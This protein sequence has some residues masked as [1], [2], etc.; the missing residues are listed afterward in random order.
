MITDYDIIM[1]HSHITTS[2]EIYLENYLFILVL[3]YS[4]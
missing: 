4:L 1:T 2:I 3:V